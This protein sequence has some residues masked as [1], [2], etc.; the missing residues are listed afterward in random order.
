VEQ[1][2]PGGV[3]TSGRAKEEGK[4]DKR[5]NIVQVPCIH[6]CKHKNDTY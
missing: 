5:V 2:L 3:G 4:R 6:A 1:V